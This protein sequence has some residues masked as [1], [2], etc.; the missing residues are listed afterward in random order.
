MEAKSRFVLLFAVYRK[1]VL[2]GFFQST[3]YC[4][5]FL[6]DV[7]SSIGTMVEADYESEGLTCPLPIPTVPSGVSMI[8]SPDQP[9]IMCPGSKAQYICNA[10][11]ID[12]REDENDKSTYEIQC[13][14]DLT[15]DI[16]TPDSEWPQCIDRLDCPTPDFYDTYVFKSS[17]Q[18]GRVVYL[19]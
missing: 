19:S 1:I 5:Q 8:N 4:F 18:T 11:G 16:P 13:K 10:G 9:E 7:A 17:W 6:S 14:S 12:V 15:Y 3:Y 2:L